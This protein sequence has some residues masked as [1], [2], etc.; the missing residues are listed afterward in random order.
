LAVVLRVGLARYATTR[1]AAFGGQDPL[2]FVED[3]DFL[4]VFCDVL[5][6]FA[7]FLCFLL[8]SCPQL[9]DGVLVLFDGGFEGPVDHFA[10]HVIVVGVLGL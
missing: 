10:G 7:V 1:S 6:E 4:L 5:I 8:A 2:L 3:F 9:L